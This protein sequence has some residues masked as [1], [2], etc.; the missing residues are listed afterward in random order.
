MFKDPVCDMM[1]DEKKATRLSEVG[2]KKFTYALLH[3]RISLTEIQVNT[4]NETEHSNFFDRGIVLMA[5]GA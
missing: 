4:Y 2:G 3:A 1:V 5:Y